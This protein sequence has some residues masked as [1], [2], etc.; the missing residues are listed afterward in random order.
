[1]AM[2][3]QC[4]I[5]S[6]EEELFSG[7]VE[8]VVAHG[9]M[10]DLGILP[11]HTPLLTDLKPGPV[12]VVLHGGQEEIFYISG[13]FMEVQPTMVKILADTATR[14]K[15]LDEAAAREAVQAAERALNEKGAEFD[16]TAAA[17]QLAEAV[18]QLRTLSELRR[19][20]GR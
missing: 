19:K 8:R 9:H 5:V 11:G 2:T 3:V 1:M 20:A 6:A 15:D 18:A 10:G 4:D 13:G 16:Y 7:L 12:R 17:V 14:A